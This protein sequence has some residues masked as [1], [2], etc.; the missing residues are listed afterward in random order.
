MIAV[1][2]AD[3]DGG[4]SDASI[5]TVAAPGKDILHQGATVTGVGPDWERQILQEGTSFATPIV[6]GNLALAMQKYPDATPNQLIQSLIHNTGDEPHELVWMRGYGH[7]LLLTNVFLAADPTVYPDVNPL[8]THF[9]DSIPGPDMIWEGVEASDVY[10]HEVERPWPAYT[11][12]P[13]AL[14]RTFGDPVPEDISEPDPASEID[15]EPA[16]TSPGAAPSVSAMPGEPSEQSEL[17]WLI[18]AFA[19]GVVLCVGI[20]VAIAVVVIRANRSSRDPVQPGERD[21]GAHL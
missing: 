5:V 20:G 13:G 18:P 7:G 11:P 8:V 19:I 17:G 4:V 3:T 15:P 10:S 14:P 6:A 2:A 1:N 16:P 21:S 12:E 9:K